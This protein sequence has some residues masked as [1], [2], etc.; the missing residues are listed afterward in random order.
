MHEDIEFL[1]NVLLNDVKT[2]KDNYFSHIYPF[3]NENISAYYKNIDFENKEVLTVV[4]SGD[5]ILNAFLDGAKSV[6]AFD[7]NPLAKH[8]AELKI[9]AIKT[10]DLKDYILFFYPSK[11]CQYMN[12]HKIFSLRDSLKVEE[13][14]FWSHCY[15][16]LNSLNNLFNYDI[17]KLKDVIKANKYLHNEENYY[18]LRNILKEKEPKYYDL[19]IFDLDELNKKY[20]IILLSNIAAYLDLFYKN[21]YTYLKKLRDIID[22]LKSVDNVV[23]LSYLYGELLNRKDA[24]GIYN[25]YRT[26]KCF[27]DNQYEYINVNKT[28]K[29]K[30]LI[31]GKD[32]V[33]I[34]KRNTYKKREK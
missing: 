7:I 19:N 26:R 12:I 10:F 28:N 33:I 5:H 9:A 21:D 31:H 34:S 15:V 17:P 1:K 25:P 27:S 30:Q 4:G 22:K 32:K 3:T 24:L 14:V 11:T 13:V 16:I 29:I 2:K 20:D 23:V 6:D 8:Y 18:K